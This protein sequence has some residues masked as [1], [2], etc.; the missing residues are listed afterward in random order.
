MNPKQ[1]VNQIP[2]TLGIKKVKS[3][4]EIYIESMKK[5]L[6]FSTHDVL[7]RG[8]DI[9]ILSIQEQT[10]KQTAEEIIKIMDNIEFDSIINIKGQIIL[11]IK[12]FI[13]GEKK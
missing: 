13:E 11:E 4:K 2:W 3:P 1:K 8:T 7:N 9:L 6:P 5:I 12:K 10:R